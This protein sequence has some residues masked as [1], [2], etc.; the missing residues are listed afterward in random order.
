MQSIQPP[1]SGFL[2]TTE[3]LRTNADAFKESRFVG[4]PEVL[5]SFAAASDRNAISKPTT[6]APSFGVANDDIDI[7]RL[8]YVVIT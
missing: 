3:E 4:K 5:Y 8:T 2:N 6:P 7:S 1:F